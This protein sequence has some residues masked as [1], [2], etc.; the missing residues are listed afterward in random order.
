MK[1]LHLMLACFYIDNYS[2][3]ENLLPKYHKRNG[4]KVKIVASLFTFDEN[5]KG[6]FLEGRRSYN[7]EY[8]IP[9]T[10]LEY[11]KGKTN[12]ILRRYVGL[13]AEVEEFCPDVIFIHGVQ[14]CDIDIVAQYAKSHKNVTVY[15][16]NHAD[17]IN[18]GRNLVSKY[19]FHKMLWRRSARIINPHTKKFYGV[20]PNR[21]DYLIREYKVPKSKVELL[22]LG[23]DDDF[24][25]KYDTIENRDEIRK[26]YKVPHDSFLVVFGGKVDSFKK[27]IFMLMDA[28][29][30]YERKKVFLLIFGSVTN[31]LRNDFEKRI[32]DNVVY[33]G[34]IDAKESYRY[35]AAADAVCF[36]STHSVFWEQVVAQGIPMIVKRWQGITHI[37]GGGNVLF[38]EQD[39]ALEIKQK[40]DVLLNKEEYNKIKEIA[41]NTGKNFLYSTIAAKAI[42]K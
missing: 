13:K 32:S 36:P 37:D 25:K 38:L 20:L 40:I 15:V 28:I 21:V 39:S 10:R 12:R 3:Q 30:E 8:D 41:K 24:V 2:Y 17:E 31:E 26:R 11:K 5:G 1:I 23:A 33:I 19:V 7:N 16:D 35:F 4:N 18:S 34:W 27:Q 42:E 6:K 29:N 14:F 22:C 9:V